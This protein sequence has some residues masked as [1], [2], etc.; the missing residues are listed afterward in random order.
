MSSPMYG[1]RYPLSA[2]GPRH[3]AGGALLAPADLAAHLEGAPGAAAQ[4]RAP[5]GAA[6]YLAGGLVAEL[7]RLEL[8]AAAAEDRGRA[9]VG[10]VPAGALGAAAA[11]GYD[12]GRRERA[13]A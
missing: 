2:R 4:D 12:H 3:E 8:G 9:A 11:A 5:D 1:G 6:E 13:D 7:A 10:G